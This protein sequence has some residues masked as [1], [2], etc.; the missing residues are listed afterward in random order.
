M[1]LNAELLADRAVVVVRAP[2]IDEPLRL[3]DVLRRAGVG[4]LEITLTVANAFA[5]IAELAASGAAVGAGTVLTTPDAEAAI[6]QGA[7]FVVT[8][9]FPGEALDVAREAGVPVLA[10]AFTPTEALAAW[11]AGAAAVKLFP[12]ETGGPQH[13]RNLRGPLPQIPF[14]PSGGVDATNA[15]AY[16][17]AGAM[18]VSCGSSVV[19]AAA[20]AAGAWDE[21][22][23]RAA[24]LVSVLAPHRSVRA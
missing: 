24:D 16:L 15:A 20:L 22:G 21:V 19:P 4:L 10:G 13:L 11:R 23:R 2:R 9:G 6:A 12:A 1:D 17:E 5:V 8:P 7:R 18:A 14:V 3:A